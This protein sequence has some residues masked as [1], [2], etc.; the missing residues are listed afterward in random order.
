MRV[1]CWLLS[2]CR[3]SSD[4]VFVIDSSSA[5]DHPRFQS[6]KSFLSGLVLDLAVDSGQTR[7][8]LVTYAGAVEERF[9]LV[10]YSSRDDL[11][12]AI[13]AMVHSTPGGPNTVTSDAIAY[14]RQVTVVRCLDR[15]L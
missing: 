12:T 8:G 2:D 11:S 7:V 1:R 9:N 13:S 14:V 5:V 3:S 4:V 6:V 15:M 10:R